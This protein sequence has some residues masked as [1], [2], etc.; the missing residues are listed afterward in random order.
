MKYRDKIPSFI[1]AS[2]RPLT[3]P[4][5]DLHPDRDRL[6]ATLREL[7]NEFREEIEA[8]EEDL[9]E[10][11]ADRAPGENAFGERRTVAEKAAAG[12]QDGY[13]AGYETGY[14]KGYDD[15]YVDKT[16]NNPKKS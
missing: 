14:W 5:L 9:R 8:Y 6:W 3:V 11:E 12:Y 4:D 13:R 7:A 2:V 10:L 16:V 15:G 1:P